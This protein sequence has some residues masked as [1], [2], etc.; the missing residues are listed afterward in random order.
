MST[1]YDGKLTAWLDMELEKL[2][3]PVLPPIGKYYE[4]LNSFEVKVK[5]PEL[6]KL[7]DKLIALTREYERKQ[8]T[9]GYDKPVEVEG[10]VY[11]GCDDD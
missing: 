7:K 8:H 5:N 11:H 9:E 10:E 2:L 6:I 4:G 1:I 3:T